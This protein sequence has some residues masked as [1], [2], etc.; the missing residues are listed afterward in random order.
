MG[1][2]LEVQMDLIET[3]RTTG[4]VRDFTEQ[5]VPDHVVS[6]IHDN[7]RFAPRGANAQS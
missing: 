1:A 4:A 6:G 7:A 2:P 3:L 5:P